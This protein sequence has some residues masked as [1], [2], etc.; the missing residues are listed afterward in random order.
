MRFAALSDRGLVRRENEDSYL[1][2]DGLLAVAD[3][4]GGHA[5]GELA[6]RTALKEIAT[7]LG[8][9]HRRSQNDIKEAFA[10]ANAAVLQ[11]ARKSGHTGMGTTLTVAVI[12][13]NRG[14]IGHVGDSRA[15]RLRSGE[16]SQLT[17]DHSLV[18]DLVRGGQ[19]APEAANDHPK[20]HIITKAIG[21]ETQVSPDIFPL[22]LEADDRL[23]LCTDG[24]TNMVSTADITGLTETP[25]LRQACGQLVEAAKAGGGADNITVVMADLGPV[26]P[27]AKM[28]TVSLALILA[29][30]A[31]LAAAVLITIGNNKLNSTF[32]LK[33]ENNKVT[34]WRGL[35]GSPI[36]L[37][38]GRIERVTPIKIDDLP[39][40]YRRRLKT[41][42]V[43]GGEKR[44]S[45]VLAD[46]ER[47]AKT[48]EQRR[49]RN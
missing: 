5:A 45:A 21:A 31:V 17:R 49:H 33:A 38:L 16:L 22:D 36:G 10:A 7:R 20:R 37:E 42:L 14:W 43:I 13:N 46:L 35:P 23:L 30:V 8:P 26:G 32:Y 12:H 41:G 9:E 19:I 25:D 47:L 4:M 44:L 15:Y 34:V 6:S 1:A 28:A 48:N 11:Q 39:P 27:N 29:L 18:A 40:Y 3:G 2:M 24:L